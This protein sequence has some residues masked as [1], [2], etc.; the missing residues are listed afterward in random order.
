MRYLLVVLVFIC[1]CKENIHRINFHRYSDSLEKYRPIETECGQER[2][3]YY[4][5]LFQ[6]EYKLLYPNG[7][8][9]RKGE[10]K[11]YDTICYPMKP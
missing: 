10:N 9:Y 7:N 3:E 5:I 2:A 6:Q 1:G 11:V 4:Y 8:P